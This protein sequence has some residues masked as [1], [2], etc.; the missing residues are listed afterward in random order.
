MFTRSRSKLARSF[1]AAVGLTVVMASPG[2]AETTL[3]FA[4]FSVEDDPNHRAAVALSE[5]VAAATNNAVT[6]KIVPNSQ[7]GGEVDVV[8]GILLGTI[9]DLY[10][11]FGINAESIVQAAIGLSDGNRSIPQLVTR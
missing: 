3:R 9:G 7:L 10:A 4:H 2:L 1:L 5:M 8:E 6:I 11:H